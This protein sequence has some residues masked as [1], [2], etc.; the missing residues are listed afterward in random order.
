MSINSDSQDGSR[1]WME[2]MSGSMAEIDSFYDSIAD[3]KPYQSSR[4]KYNC[5]VLSTS[6]CGINIELHKM[7]VEYRKCKISDCSLKY[8]LFKCIKMHEKMIWKD[9]ATLH[10][11]TSIG[12]FENIKNQIWIR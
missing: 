5:T 4:G 8:K 1:G 7:D 3:T 12:E 11:C 9:C 10:Y 2:I 6:N